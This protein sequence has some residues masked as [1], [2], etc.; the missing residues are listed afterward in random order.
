MQRLRQLTHPK[1]GAFRQ[2]RFDNPIAPAR[3]N[4]RT[5]TYGRNHSRPHGSIAAEQFRIGYDEIRLL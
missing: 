3:T 1:Q 2:I 4:S 5:G